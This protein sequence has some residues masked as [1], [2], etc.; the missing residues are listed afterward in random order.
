MRRLGAERNEAQNQLALIK[1]IA[2]EPVRV[3]TEAEVRDMLQHFDDILRRA[4]AGQLGDDPDVARDILDT[5]TGGRIDMYQQGERREMQGW[6]QGRFTVR[7]LD[8]LVEKIAGT[9]PAKAGDGIEVVIDFKRPRKTDSD[10]DKAVRIWL[11]GHMSKEIA[12]Q[13]GLGETYVSRLLRIGTEQMGTTS[14]RY[15]KPTEDTAGRSDSCATLSEDRRRSEKAVVG[16][17]LS[18]GSHRQTTG[19]Q[20][21]HGQ[22][23]RS[24]FV[25]KPWFTGSEIRGLVEQG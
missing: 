18:D 16:R 2:V 1:A 11:D 8:V 6:L 4:A 13:L 9:R 14:R 20:H 10:A 21:D 17:A 24:F 12:T 22:G 7:I 15:P 25:R 5:L 23:G 3:P 19:L